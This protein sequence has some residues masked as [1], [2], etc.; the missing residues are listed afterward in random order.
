MADWFSILMS[1]AKISFLGGNIS[2]SH[3]IFSRFILSNCSHLYKVIVCSLRRASFELVLSFVTHGEITG[4]VWTLLCRNT[5]PGCRTRHIHIKQR[6][7][8]PKATINTYKIR[9]YYLITYLCHLCSF[10]LPSCYYIQS[11]QKFLMNIVKNNIPQ[12]YIWLNLIMIV[13]LLL[14]VCAGDH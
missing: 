7:D 10:V 1:K 13:S 11:L 3:R 4:A 9:C 6:K 2:I 5:Q 12:R 8:N 14:F